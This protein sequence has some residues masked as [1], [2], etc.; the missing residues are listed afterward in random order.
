MSHRKNAVSVLI[1]LTMAMAACSDPFAPDTQTR[2]PYETSSDGPFVSPP[3]SVL[4]QQ[5]TR[6]ET[7]WGGPA[8]ASAWT[9]ADVVTFA[10]P[11][12]VVGESLMKR[13]AGQV[14]LRLDASGFEP[15]EA[16]T[17]WA[18]VFNHPEACVGE[19]DDPDLFENPGTRADLLYVAGGVANRSGEIRYTGRVAESDAGASILPLFGL[20]APGILDAQAAEIHLVVRSHG[21]VIQGLRQ[22]QTTT[23]NGG[24]TGFGAEFGTPGP[25]ECTDLYFASHYAG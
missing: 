16:A 13:G 6:F 4:L 21:P 1:T 24:C 8:A 7:A 10:D 3:G 12:R 22:A 18:V 17:L 9:R 2:Y 14:S 20:P 25:N 11:D 19:C 23:F 5:R 15:G